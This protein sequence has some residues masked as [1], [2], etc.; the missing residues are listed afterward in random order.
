MTLFSVRVSMKVKSMAMKSIVMAIFLFVMT[1]IIIVV[2]INVDE[3]VQYHVIACN[4]YDNAKY[5]TFMNSCDGSS[6]LNLLGIHIKR[7]YGYIGSFSSYFY[8][9]FFRLHPSILTQKLVGVFFSIIFV[10]TLMLLEDKNRMSVMVMFGLS[11]PI[12]YQLVNDT[13]PVRY[14]IFMS[15]FTPLFVKFILR[16]RQNYVKILLNIVL[17]FMLFLAVEDK[18]FFL[19]F[20][21]SI[22]LLVIAYNYEEKYGQ[23]IIDSINFLLKELWISIII[24]VI[25]TLLY[26]IVAKTSSGH[27]FVFELMES[28]KAYQYSFTGVLKTFL[29]FMINFQKF[30]HFVYPDGYSKFRL[31]DTSF[32]LLVWVYGFFLIAKMCKK[33]VILLPPVKVFFTSLALILSIVVMLFSRN[34]WAGHHFIYTYIYALLVVCQS[35]SYVIEMKSQ[36]LI[37][38]SFFSILL[39]SQ[40]LLFVPEPLSSW[41]R[42]K[43]FEYVKQETIARNYMIVHI[44]LGTYYISSLYGHK[45]QLSIQLGA[46]ARRNRPIQIGTP[47]DNKTVTEIINLSE[48][49]KRRILC[50]CRGPDCNSENLSDSFLKRIGFEEVKLSTSDWK[51]YLEQR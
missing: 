14:G 41:E 49:V 51:V 10:T 48:M 16:I 7:A 50:I 39:A 5:H 31:L 3:S 21:P 4:F 18:I 6:D 30:S 28:Y 43:I 26:L 13:G 46:G 24:F 23:R 38:Y 44:S 36:F 12:S 19:Y 45:D 27:I 42:Y 32:S 8:Y 22:T 33:E 2:P 29:S 35:T 47:L 17:G 40:L 11:F 25:L 20:I 15:V 1:M 9:P 34:A 37:L